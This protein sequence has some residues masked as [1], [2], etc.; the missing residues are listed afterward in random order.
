M[1]LQSRL[2]WQFKWGSKVIPGLYDGF[3]INDV[4]RDDGLPPYSQPVT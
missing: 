3:N 1:P 4:A 2:E